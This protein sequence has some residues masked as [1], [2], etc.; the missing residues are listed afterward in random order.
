MT[1]TNLERI[2]VARNDEKQEHEVAEGIPIDRRPQPSITPLEIAV[3]TL[4][5]RGLR[6]FPVRACGK[7]PL[8]EEWPK[9][10]TT[11]SATLRAWFSEFRGCNWGLATGLDSGI[12][13]IDVDGEEGAAAIRELSER[14]GYK[15]TETLTVKTARGKHL[16][17]RYP[18][19][20][21]IRNSAS[22]LA[23]AL[24]VRGEGGYVIVPPS[25]HASGDEYT[26]LSEDA[27]VAP[28]RWLLEML[29]MP[30]EGITAWTPT[31]DIIVEGQRNASLTSL[32]GAMRRRGATPHG[33]EA[34]LQAENTV[35]CRPPLSETEIRSIAR[36][37]SRYKPA[38]V[39]APQKA[40]TALVEIGNVLRDVEDFFRRFL[41]LPSD[42]PLVL[43]LYALATY[44]FETFEQFP[45]LVVTSPVK[46]C[47]KTRLTEVFEQVAATVVR[48]V[49]ISVAALFRLIQKMKPTL[50]IDEAE[51]LAGKSERAQELGAILNSGNR[52]NT[53]VPRCT[54]KNHE[55]AMFSIYCP[56]MVCAIRDVSEPTKD[57]AIVL[58]MQKKLSSQHIER[59]I[60]RNV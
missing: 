9:K 36:S 37:V 21:E 15:W 26:F 29:S 38:D 41:V 49:G 35:R 40:A 28:P 10:A 13:V 47:G 55:L 25:I 53:V 7:V 6:L 18:E 23:P 34:A 5:E 22:K 52:K 51:S 4:A 32:A 57:R 1:H 56:K 2:A 16:Y 27:P 17:F 44:C 45:Y 50:I 19:S 12:F 58:V 20:A 8:I 42:I 59:F 33:I 11:N 24:D 39:S 14:H 3:L 31:G 43:G 46:G 48:T 60:G 54:G 30:A